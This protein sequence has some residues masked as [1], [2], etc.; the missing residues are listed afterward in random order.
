MTMTHTERAA[1]RQE[2]AEYAVEHGVD[3]AALHFNTS[4]A[5][6]YTS[7]RVSGT[8]AGKMKADK[9][10]EIAEYASLHGSKEACVKYQVS[11]PHVARCLAENNM[12]AKVKSNASA[13]T[14]RTIAL[15]QRKMKQSEIAARLRVSRQRIGQI[16]EQCEAN[17]VVLDVPLKE[18]E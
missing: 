1:R 7:C 4:L 2:I 5:T 11:Q 8:P 12:R 3:A 14:F 18:G 15:L 16:K 17:G 9:R 10:R 6:V 13:N